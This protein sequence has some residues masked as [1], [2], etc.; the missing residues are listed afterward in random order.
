MRPMQFYMNSYVAAVFSTGFIF[1]GTI[2]ANAADP[3]SWTLTVFDTFQP[4]H[5]IPTQ[6]TKPWM[7][8]ITV[9]TKGKVHFEYY[10][11]E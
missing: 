5:F 3:D 2:P 11:A 9:L 4:N 7:A 1:A 10:P 8:R 6:G